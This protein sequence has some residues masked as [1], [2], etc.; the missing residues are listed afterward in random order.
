MSFAAYPPRNDSFLVTQLWDKHM[1]SG[2][3]ERP[4]GFK[5]KLGDPTAKKLTEELRR[6]EE[7]G[8]S[9]PDSEGVTSDQADFVTFKRVVVAKKGKWNRFPQEML[10]Q[11]RDDEDEGDSLPPSE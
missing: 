10:D 3:R 2:W 5:P 4:S 7:E 8:D 1:A 11:M 6:F 9:V